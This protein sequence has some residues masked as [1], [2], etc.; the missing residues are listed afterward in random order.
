VK[1]SLEIKFY[2]IIFRNIKMKISLDIKC[3]F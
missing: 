2:F 3:Y 1:V